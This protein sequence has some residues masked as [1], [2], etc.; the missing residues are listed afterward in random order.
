MQLRIYQISTALANPLG[1]RGKHWLACS[2]VG[3]T[4]VVKAPAMSRRVKE[5]T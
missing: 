1:S 2:R 4:L 3:M 5:G